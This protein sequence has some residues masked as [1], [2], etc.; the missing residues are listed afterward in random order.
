MKTSKFML[1]LLCTPLLLMGNCKGK[2]AETAK[3][4]KTLSGY[5]VKNDY[6]FD[7][8]YACFV[9]D[10]KDSLTTYLG[11]GRTMSNN[12]D[13]PDFANDMVAAIACRPVS[14]STEIVVTKIEKSGEAANVHFEVK[15]GDPISYTIQP[16]LVFSVSKDDSVRVV[17]F[18][19]DNKI[20]KEIPLSTPNAK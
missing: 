18:T 4:L 13:E 16:L 3:G 8:D 15:T 9:F 19:T 5:F 14:T 7:G 10:D 20:V 17:K 1:I 12:V 6:S 2:E 11:V